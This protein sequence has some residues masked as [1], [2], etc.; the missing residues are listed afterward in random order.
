MI[1]YLSYLVFLIM[2][3]LRGEELGDWVG[4]V[5]ALLLDELLAVVVIAE[6]TKGELGTNRMELGI[7]WDMSC[8][9]GLF[10]WILYWLLF[11]LA[12]IWAMV[13]A[14]PDVV[15]L[16]LGTTILARW[17]P[18]TLAPTAFGWF[19][20]ADTIRLCILVF[21]SEDEDGLS[22]KLLKDWSVTLF[23]FWVHNF[24]EL[25]S[26]WFETTIGI[27]KRWFGAVWFK[28]KLLVL[29]S[30][31]G[32][33]DPEVW[34]WLL[35]ALDWL[36]CTLPPDEVLKFKFSL[37]IGHFHQILTMLDFEFHFSIYQF[38]WIK[39]KFFFLIQ[40]MNTNEKSMFFFL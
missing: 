40:R 21:L 12:H 30:D 9:E 19:D 6:L 17:L 18:S 5:T 15:L 22:M 32:V 38:K 20:C 2:F 29:T 33:L 37:P 25:E 36:I 13:V 27:V 4:L 31:I 16:P 23:W 26:I 28:I 14:W 3:G 10:V 8:W 35:V 1:K 34:L 24:A 39:V 7:I 11:K